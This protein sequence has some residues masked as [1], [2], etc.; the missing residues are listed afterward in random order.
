[1]GTSVFLS[2]VPVAWVG[3]G[4]TYVRCSVVCFRFPCVVL[5]RGRIVLCWLWALWMVCGASALRLR[6]KPIPC[7]ETGSDDL[8]TCTRRHVILY[9]FSLITGCPVRSDSFLQDIFIIIQVCVNLMPEVILW[10]IRTISSS[11]ISSTNLQDHF[12]KVFSSAF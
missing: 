1:M 5:R 10:I 11:E 2:K 6:K 3:V 7:V 12:Q 4:G 8:L 9:I